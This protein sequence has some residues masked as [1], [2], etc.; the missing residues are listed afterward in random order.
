MLFEKLV[1]IK[2]TYVYKRVITDDAT[3]RFNQV[4]YEPD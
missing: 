4:F 2:Y 3:E 1:E